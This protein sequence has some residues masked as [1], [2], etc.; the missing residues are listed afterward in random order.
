RPH[1]HRPEWFHLPPR[2]K[3][4]SLSVVKGPGPPSL[5]MLVG[6][7]AG[8]LPSRVGAW[9]HFIQGGHGRLS[10]DRDY[11]AALGGT[12][13]AGRG[14]AANATAHARLGLAGG[15]DTAHSRLR[16]I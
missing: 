9:N 12:R 10:H 15:N 4:H 14:P 11:E 5:A 2:A 8:E 7:Q 13:S 6:M 1:I 16:I 3:R